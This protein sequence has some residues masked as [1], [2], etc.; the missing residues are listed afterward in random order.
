MRVLTY[1]LF[2]APYVSESK[3]KRGERSSIS[4]CKIHVLTSAKRTLCNVN[5]LTASVNVSS[6]STS[7]GV[8]LFHVRVLAGAKINEE[9]LKKQKHTQTR[10]PTGPMVIKL[11]SRLL[12][13]ARKIKLW[14]ADCV[15]LCVCI[16]MQTLDETFKS[17][18]PLPEPPCFKF[19]LFNGECQT[20]HQRAMYHETA[21]KSI[22]RKNITLV[23]PLPLLHRPRLSLNGES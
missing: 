12:L 23:P 17:T 22:I 14:T 3:K 9:F 15:C 8:G 13:R 6:D 20:K 10:R 19:T 4:N 11:L 16:S 21:M 7:F 5:I 18:L 2:F 1:T